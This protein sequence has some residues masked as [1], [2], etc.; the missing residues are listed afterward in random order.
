VEHEAE[1]ITRAKSMAR[2]ITEGLVLFIGGEYKAFGKD[3][4]I[5]FYPV[6]SIF[7]PGLVPGIIGRLKLNVFTAEEVKVKR[8]KWL[9]I[10]VD[11]FK[12]YLL[13]NFPIPDHSGTEEYAPC[14]K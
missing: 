5:S 3:N 6:W 8:N 1:K 13:F 4:I 11:P 12:H 2:V 10:G 7:S 9:L 14:L